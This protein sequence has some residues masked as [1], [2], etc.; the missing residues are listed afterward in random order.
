[1]YLIC[2]KCM[3][4][5]VQRSCRRMAMKLNCIVAPDV[6]HNGNG[7]GTSSGSRRTPVHHEARSSTR[8]PSCSSAHTASA[9]AGHVV[10]SGS[11]GRGK[12]IATLSQVMR[13]MET[14]P[15]QMQVL[16]SM[17]T[18]HTSQRFQ[19]MPCLMPHVLLRHKESRVR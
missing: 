12:A 10:A 17:E 9:S 18:P 15:P 1:M 4:Q 16:V 2:T 5:R 6:A 3:V 7:Q 19:W 14:P 11:H 13:T 8:T